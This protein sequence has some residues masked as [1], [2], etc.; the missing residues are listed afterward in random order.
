[1][2]AERKERKKSIF[3]IFSF[4]SHFVAV[5]DA[6]ACWM[7]SRSCHSMMSLQFRFFVFCFSLFNPF[8]IPFR[9]LNE[10]KWCLKRNKIGNF[11]SWAEL[12][13]SF[14]VRFGYLTE[15]FRFISTYIFILSPSLH[16]HFIISHQVTW[17]F[18]SFLFYLHSLQ[19]L[20][21]IHRKK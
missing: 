3:W 18:S 20:H 19:S 17:D 9:C 1:M 14:E 15:I 21:L 10:V 13:L 4:F 16:H 8:K 12:D 7:N 2:C 5:D 6:A 11:H